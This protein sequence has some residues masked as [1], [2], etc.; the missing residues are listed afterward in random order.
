M[1]EEISKEDRDWLDSLA[2]KPPKDAD[3][4]VS[5]E[6]LA[7]RKALA[8]RRN[9]I[10]ADAARVGNIGLEEIR[11][12]LQREGLMGSPDKAEQEYGWLERI[13]GFFGIGSGTG[14]VNRFPVWGL[15]ATLALAI[16]LTMQMPRQE[17]DE[18]TVVRGDPHATTLVVENPEARANEIVAGIK[19]LS[20]DAVQMTR[21][22]DGSIQL[23][24][25]DSQPV[26]DYLLAQRIEAVVVEGN[27]QILVVPLKK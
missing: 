1:S 19:S 3:P 13:K 8:S 20:P 22:S 7:V 27:V 15:A 21:L 26:Q 6:A 24:I 16:L 9:E 4:V 25:R 14:S 2:G 18:A 17:P 11:A 10:E 5:A 23:R 12:R